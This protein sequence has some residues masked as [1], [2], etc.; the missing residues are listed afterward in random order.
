VHVSLESDICL[1]Q[2]RRT[3][4]WGC[5]NERFAGLM[6]S[7]GVCSKGIFNVNG[8]FFIV[9]H[10]VIET[11][12]RLTHEF[13]EHCQKEGFTFIDEPLL[14]YGMLMLCGNPYLHTVRETAELWASDWTGHYRDVLPDGQP[15]WFVD[16]FTEERILV[17]PAI[18]HAMRSK[19]ALIA[20]ANAG[21]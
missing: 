8:G 4:W 16:Y 3:D 13:W 21:G 19:T 2:N 7:K 14:A 15:W 18:V 20:A 12:Y 10:D 11:F 9:H 6:R 17:N 5:P 1:P